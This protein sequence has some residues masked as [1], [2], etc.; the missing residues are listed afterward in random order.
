MA[1]GSY[2]V[3]HTC[4]LLIW[5]IHLLM[6]LQHCYTAQ[7]FVHWFWTALLLRLLME[8][9]HCIYSNGCKLHK[10]QLTLCL[11]Y[12]FAQD[13]YTWTFPK[14]WLTTMD[15][16]ELNLC[17]Y[18]RLCSCQRHTLRVLDNWVSVRNFTHCMHLDVLLPRSVYKALSV[19]GSLSNSILPTHL[20]T[21]VTMLYM[22]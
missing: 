8:L 9:R 14:R 18:C 6:T 3:Q 16:V 1:L 17:P 10:L 4:N 21:I 7:I 15:F 22:F 5:Q 19:Q 13:L 11:S 2:H 12:A 20:L